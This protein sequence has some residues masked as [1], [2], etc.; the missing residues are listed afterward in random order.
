[1][2]KA[3]ILEA[4]GAENGTAG[5]GGSEPGDQKQKESPDYYGEVRIDEYR[6]FEKNGDYKIFRI[7]DEKQRAKFWK[8]AY[9]FVNSKRVGYSQK[10][11][12]TL[13]N[14]CKD[15]GFDNYEKLNKNVECDCSSL[16]YTCA[17]IAGIKGWSNWVTADMM[18]K[19]EKVPGLELLTDKKYYNGPN[20][21]K[22]GD[23]LVKNG[24]TGCIYQEATLTYQQEKEKIALEVIAGKWGNGTDRIVRLTEAG[25]D[26][27]A[28]QD[29]V[30][31]ILNPERKYYRVQ[32]GAYSI[33]ENAEKMLAEMRKYFPDEQPTL[34]KTKSGL[35]KVILGKYT[36]KIKAE[37]L[38]ILLQL[39]GYDTMLIKT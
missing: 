8:A 18:T 37:K 5:W 14:A 12:L 36:D 15:L 21:L 27:R 2:S 20:Y 31:E 25:Y 26:Y 3:Y 4:M 35:W 23:V 11:R 34:M 33:Q 29:R 24:H 19:L 6:K 10:N 9:F 1:M 13:Y 7:V 22:S 32:V 16:M 39:H 30:N 17:K 38:E 28:I